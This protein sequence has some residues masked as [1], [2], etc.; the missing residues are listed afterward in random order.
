MNWGTKGEVQY[1]FYIK[2]YLIY[3][4]VSDKKIYYMVR[5]RKFEITNY[6]SCLKSSLD[7]QNDLM[8]LIGV[9]GVGKT[10]LL[11]GLQLLKKLKTGRRMYHSSIRDSIGSLTK[12]SATLS[13][14]GKS[15]TFKC[16]IRYET[17]DKNQ[18]DIL[19]AK[20]KVNFSELT[21]NPKWFSF[22]LELFDYLNHQRSDNP[23]IVRHFYGINFIP[24]P[25]EVEIISEIGAFIKRISYYSASQFSD[26]TKCPISFELEDNKGYRQIRN[27]AYHEKF[28]NDLFVNSKNN[29]KLFEKFLT[30]VNKQGIGL[31]D[32]IS[33]AEY[34]MPSSSYEV[35]SGGKIRKI[36]RNR[37]LIIPYITI[38]KIQLSPNQLSEGTFKTLALIFYIITDDNDL[39]LIE[40]PEVCVHHGLLNSIISLILSQSKKKQ[41][42][43]STHSDFVLDRLQPDNLLIVKKMPRKGT[44]VKPLS[45][46]LS[47]NDYA[48]LKN[49]LSET[50]NLGEYWKEGGFE[51]E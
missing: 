14:R 11:N 41:I 42:V 24:S 39:L 34:D 35:K 13:Y 10:N 20:L 51:N 15:I 38:D 19:D 45:K 4:C 29:K 27:I 18:D 7:L 46:F 37:Q 30:T 33:F 32:D 12:I 47:K 17:D 43:I 9:N 6:R 22:P 21:G 1:V 49:Y 40:E 36:E 48:A 8:C 23:N 5:L 3:L 2:Y 28:L 26:P 31:I 25:K 16:D 50:G 44:T